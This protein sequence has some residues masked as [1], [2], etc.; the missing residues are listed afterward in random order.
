MW[1]QLELDPLSIA[2]ETV[3]SKNKDIDLQTALYTADKTLS[4]H[5]LSMLLN[6]VIDAAVNG[7]IGNYDRIFFNPAYVKEHAEDEGR[8]KNLRTLIEEQ[9][10]C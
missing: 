7:G 1:L 2:L 5:P 10:S 6:G 8:V 9:V 4:I 3:E